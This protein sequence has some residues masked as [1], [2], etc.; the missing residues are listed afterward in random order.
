M[1]PLALRDIAQELGVHESTISRVTNNKYIDT[2]TGAFELKRFFSRPMLSSNGRA[3][4][5]TAIRGLIAEMVQAETPQAPLSDVAICRQL[6][7]Q[8]LDVARR[9]V[10]KYRQ[11]LRIE[12]VDKRRRVA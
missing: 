9:T 2:P 3:C 6:A 8:G 12:P 5:G 10:T 1:K 4:S 7:E 11:M